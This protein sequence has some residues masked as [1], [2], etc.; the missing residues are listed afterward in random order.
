MM[1]GPVPISNN[2]LDK[3]VSIVREYT[4]DELGGEGFVQVYYHH[5]HS[6]LPVRD[7][8]NSRGYDFKTEPC[9]ERKA[10]NYCRNCNQ[11]VLKNVAKEDERR[12]VFLFTQCR[13][14]DLPE[15]K[16]R[17][18]TGYIDKR[19]ILDIDGR[20]A[21]QGPMKVVAFKDSFPLAEIGIADIRG[22]KR[23]GKERT[24]TILSGL[25]EA[26]NIYDKYIERVEELER[27]IARPRLWE[28]ETKGSKSRTVE[29]PKD[30]EIYD[31]EGC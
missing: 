30:E 4:S 5:K 3:S 13:K 25:Q 23:I 1:K 31:S 12:Y 29:P 26:D 10:E 11:S 7:V 17:R 24:E 18:I 27:D 8:T 21:I 28:E 20:T 22:F 15:Y 14:K 2:D 19:R 16:S 9:F 6:R